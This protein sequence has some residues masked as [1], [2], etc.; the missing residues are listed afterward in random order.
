[1]RHLKHLGEQGGSTAAGL[2]GREGLINW[3]DEKP[4]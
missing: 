2:H 4:D 3:M 1:M